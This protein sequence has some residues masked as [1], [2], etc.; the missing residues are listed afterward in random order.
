MKGVFTDTMSWAI[1]RANA[2]PTIEPKR[3]EWIDNTSETWTPSK[4]R[5][6]CG[7]VVHS[8]ATD[9]TDFHAKLKMNFCPQC[10][11]DMRKESE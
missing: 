3:G 11:A 10:G 1:A 6:E 5:S 9:S 7:L 4:K 2:I 8:V